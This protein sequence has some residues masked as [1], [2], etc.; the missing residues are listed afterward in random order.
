[1]AH[2]DPMKPQVT[3]TVGQ[4]RGTFAA[5]DR[6]R[7]CFVSQVQSSVSPHGSPTFSPDELEASGDGGRQVPVSAAFAE[8]QPRKQ[9][10]RSPARPIA[11][12]A[13]SGLLD[14]LHAL[15]LAAQ[16]ARRTLKTYRWLSRD[17][18]PVLSRRAGHWLTLASLLMSLLATVSNAVDLRQSGTAIEP[19][20]DALSL[21][22]LDGRVGASFS[23]ERSEHEFAG[24][25]PRRVGHA[26]VGVLYDGFHE[27]R[28]S[29]RD[30]SEMFDSICGENCRLCVILI[31]SEHHN[32]PSSAGGTPPGPSSDREQ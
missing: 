22:I 7:R 19:R 16:R 32:A 17:M 1:M 12:Q 15:R 13:G 9:H 2:V 26:V 23:S 3:A 24:A 11:P 20:G 31:S 29:D 18:L 30:L 5:R 25:F 27:A 21:L 14:V 8:R 28:L 4:T 10:G 6:I